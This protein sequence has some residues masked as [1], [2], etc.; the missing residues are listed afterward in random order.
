MRQFSSIYG[1]LERVTTI[2]A[3]DNAC[4]KAKVTTTVKR[5]PCAS[6]ASPLLFGSFLMNLAAFVSLEDISDALPP[7]EEEVISVPMDSVLQQAYS[8]LEDDVR[9]AL[10]EHHGNASVVSTAMNALLLYPDRPFGLGTLYGFD[11]D[12]ETGERERFVISEPAG[13]SQE[14]AYAKERRLIEET[15][16]ELAVGRNVHL[17]AV[18]T[19][20]RDVTRRLQ[21]LLSKEGIHA[22]ILTS[23][24]PPADREAWYE[25]QLRNGM[26]VCIAHPKLCSVGLDLLAFPV[27]LFYQ[28]GYSTYTLRQASRRSWRIGQHQ[29]IRVG[30]MTYANSAQEACLR[31][32]GKKLM[33]SLPREGKLHADGLQAMDSDDD[34]LTP[35]ARELVTCQGVGEAGSE[36]WKSLAVRYGGPAEPEVKVEPPVATSD[37]EPP[38]IS[39]WIRP[40]GPPV[41]LSLF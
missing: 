39:T 36:I 27:L 30:Y 26:R 33:A 6:C 23:A 40:S 3:A 31:L 25:R 4:S 12:P 18:Y 28:T 14:P 8:K 13:L 15:K 41:Q 16:R 7:F 9:N 34:L 35:M 37:E 11:R 5:R 1:V 19:K 24:V 2:E 38:G 32:M 10:R 29:L 22:E 20:K 21:Q 17:F